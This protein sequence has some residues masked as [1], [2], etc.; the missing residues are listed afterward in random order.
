MID[1]VCDCTSFEIE[2]D[3]TLDHDDEEEFNDFEDKD[4]DFEDES[5]DPDFDQSAETE[6]RVIKVEFTLDYMK[7]VIDFYDAR[8]SKGRRKHTWKSTQHRFKSVPH[9]QYI[10]RFRHYVEQHGTKR[11]K[12]QTID[13]FVYDMFEE[14][15]DNVL[16]VHNRDLKRWA[17][18]KAA[19]DSSLT[20]EASEH[21]LRLFKH[22][23][24]ICSRKITKLV[25]RHHVE[26]TEAIIK[27]GDSFVRDAKQQM[28]NY[29][30]EEI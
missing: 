17:L 1:N 30:Y 25:T 11:E 27:C 21:W 14:A 22:Q 5:I 7:K 29:A 19:E 6:N 18:Q 23:H 26:D 15:R 4:V 24:R 13:D 2:S 3:A 20:F 10:T 28:Q 9:R 8:D 12:I 16:P